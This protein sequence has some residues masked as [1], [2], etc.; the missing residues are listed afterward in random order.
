MTLSF[1]FNVNLKQNKM[2]NDDVSDWLPGVSIVDFEKVNAGWVKGII[3][4]SNTH[5]L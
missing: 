1:V 4:T 2:M 5:W 3:K